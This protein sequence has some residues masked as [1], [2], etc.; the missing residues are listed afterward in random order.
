MSIL[1]DRTERRVV[2]S[3]VEKELSVP[4]SYPLTLNA[5]V[6]ACNQKSNREP[7]M[8]LAEHEVAGAVRSLM[9]R[10]WVHEMELAGGRTRRYAH[11]AGEQLGLDSHG[12]AILAEL[13]LRGPQS[14]NE[15]EKRCGRMRP[16]SG[17]ADVEQRLA[18]MSRLPVPF[19]RLLGRR[20]GERL[21]RW[22]HLLG[23]EEPAAGES[24]VPPAAP[25]APAASPHAG[26]PPVSMAEVVA[27][28]ERLERQ[29]ADL[30]RAS[31]RGATDE[32][33]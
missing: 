20:H 5:L 16:F 6:L 25:A 21:P 8:S 26:A 30:R 32:A 3:L 15:L 24:P 7:E 11:R 10:G 17:L 18:A 27:R 29:V 9:D 19:V 14:A 33:P 31:P 4:E 1:L 2:G 13:L 22:E 23:S 28:L 12:L